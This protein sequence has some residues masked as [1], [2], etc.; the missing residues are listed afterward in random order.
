MHPTLPPHCPSV[1]IDRHALLNLRGVRAQYSFGGSARNE[2]LVPKIVAHGGFRTV[3]VA[4][5]LTRTK[6]CQVG[7]TIGQLSTN[8]IRTQSWADLIII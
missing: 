7:G 1:D 8:T 4:E 2:S 5:R 3:E 6:P